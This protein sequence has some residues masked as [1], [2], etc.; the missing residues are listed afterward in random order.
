MHEAPQ[1]CLLTLPF[2][3][4]PPLCRRN[5]AQHE[6]RKADPGASLETLTRR[7][8]DGNAPAM[9]GWTHAAIL[10]IVAMSA[11]GPSF[12]GMGVGDMSPFSRNNCIMY[13]EAALPDVRRGEEC[14]TPTLP[15]G[16]HQVYNQYDERP[17]RQTA[18]SRGD[19]CLA[20]YSGS[21][22]SSLQYHRSHQAAARR[23]TKP[24]V[25]LCLCGACVTWLVF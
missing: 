5:L 15:F 20:R 23:D 11:I 9:T 24:G 18:T 12:G 19:W 4:Y 14:V 1:G 13:V 16:P 21:D 25:C 2:S 17:Q 3:P 6:L 22:G 7:W 8:L 10:H